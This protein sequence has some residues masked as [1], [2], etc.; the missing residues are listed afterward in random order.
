MVESL[1]CRQ[2]ISRERC[3]RDGYST[4]YEYEVAEAWRLGL[5]AMYQQN[6]FVSNRR[7]GIHNKTGLGYGSSLLLESGL[8]NDVPKKEVVGSA[9]I[10]FQKRSKGGAWLSRVRFGPDV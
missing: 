5:S 9:T 7:L 8:I 4:M 3:A 2:S 1:I 10:C 6:K